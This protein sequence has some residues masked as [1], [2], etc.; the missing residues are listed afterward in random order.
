[1]NNI[2]VIFDSCNDLINN[3]ILN[4]NNEHK[5][6][7]EKKIKINEIN[8]DDYCHVES[9][10]ININNDDYIPT[11]YRNLNIKQKQNNNEEQK[12]NNNEEQKQNN[13][14]NLIKLEEYNIGI[15]NLDIEFSKIELK[16]GIFLNSKITKFALLSSFVASV[17]IYVTY[18]K[19]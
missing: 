4:K 11:V 1:M 16:E 12:Q 9:T 17:L 2:S 13:N 5:L 3:V 10:E 7:N 15:E 8:E 19:K 18:K 6:N 14:K